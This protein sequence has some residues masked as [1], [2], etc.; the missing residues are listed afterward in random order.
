[1]TILLVAPGGFPR[2]PLRARRG[3][4]IPTEMTVVSLRSGSKTHARIIRLVA[5]PPLT[6]EDFSLRHLEQHSVG[7]IPD[8]FYSGV[9]VFE[10]LTDP[11]AARQP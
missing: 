11:E 5:S 4:S 9:H 10:A 3:F 8:R 7:G 2:G 1:M 6:G